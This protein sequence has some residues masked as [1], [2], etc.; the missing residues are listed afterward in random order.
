MNLNKD[1]YEVIE[2][3]IQDMNFA[4]KDIQGTNGIVIRTR[5]KDMAD[6]ICSTMNHTHKLSCCEDAASSNGWR[7]ST[8]CDNWVMCY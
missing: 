5:N 2:I 1:R 7:H 8:N 6:S 4:I 3:S